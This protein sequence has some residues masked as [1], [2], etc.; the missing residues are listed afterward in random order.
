[1]LK[2]SPAAPGFSAKTVE[3]VEMAP[4]ERRARQR[5][6]PRCSV[7][8]VPAITAAHTPRQIHRRRHA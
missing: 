4:W 2:K 1:M 3:G 8:A 7:G 6:A 5:S